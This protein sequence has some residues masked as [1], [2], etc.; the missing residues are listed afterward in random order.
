MLF[1]RVAFLSFLGDPFKGESDLHWREALRR[2]GLFDTGINSEEVSFLL[3]DDRTELEHT[4]LFS[5]ERIPS[6]GD[7]TGD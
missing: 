3:F 6:T 4:V 5:E 1:A 2:L 7:I